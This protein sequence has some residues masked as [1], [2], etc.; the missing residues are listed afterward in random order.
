[1][2]IERVESILAR[3]PSLHPK[4]ID[5]SLGRIERL[6]AALDHPERKLPPVIHVAGTNGKGS[7]VAFMRAMLEAAGLL[8]HVYTSPHLV[9]FNE[10]VRLGAPGGGVLIDDDMF[11]DVLGR[12]EQV[13]AGQ[14][15]SFFEITTAAAFLA[16]SEHPADCLLLEVGLG[17]RFDATN[18]IDH[19]AVT[20]VTPVSFD[21][22]EF[23]GDTVEKIA[24]EKAGILKR[25]T[26][27]VFAAQDVHT[28][29][30]L[31][32]QAER[33]GLRY[34]VGG[35]DFATREEHG[36]LIYEDERGLL[37]LPL[38]KLAGRHQH[39]NAAAAIAAVRLLRPT[40]PTSAI[41]AGLRSAKWSA[42]LQR[43]SRGPIPDLAPSDAEIWL[44]GGHNADGGRVLAEA[45]GEREDR[46]ARPLVLVCGML[47]TKDVRTFLSP[48]RE[49][50][51]ELIA[52]PIE[53]DQAGRS[54]EEVAS[55]ARALGIPAA[56]CP[57]VAHALDY[58]SARPWL[59]PPRILIAGSLHLAGEVLR[60]NGTP[61]T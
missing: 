44:D 46:A 34:S 41:E 49:L 39:I 42:R 1:M 13:N 51:Q 50:S 56:S 10:R 5:L 8:V 20:V 9:R 26:P 47:T 37:D 2:T 48:F 45:M 11:S 3:L 57:S 55:A 31:T 23:L 61:P 35:Q 30:V 22:P 36:R 43:L 32:Y 6:L 54:A 52:V 16:F 33:L 53:G 27:A 25:G 12:C 7:T 15:I 40:I 29:Q 4:R 58:L 21:H 14:S 18:V 28:L 17:G 60:L 38:P 19:P 24:F 59:V